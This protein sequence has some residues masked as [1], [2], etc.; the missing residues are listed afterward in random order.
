MFRRCLAFQLNNTGAYVSGGKQNVT[1][2]MTPANMR[3]THSAQRQECRTG[4]SAIQAP[5]T[6]PSAAPP[7]PK[8]PK[9]GNM[10]VFSIGVNISDMLPPTQT[11]GAD[12]TRQAQNRSTI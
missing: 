7:N 6:G 1:N 9:S 3:V 4:D 12:P 5:M 2:R 8:R 10:Y 11:E